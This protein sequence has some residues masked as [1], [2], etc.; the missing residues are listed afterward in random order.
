M[1][2]VRRADS[3]KERRDFLAVGR[4]LHE[5]DPIWT[6]PLYDDLARTLSPDNPLFQDGRA[7]RELY[8]AYRGERAVGRVLGHVHHAHNQRHG[9]RAGFFG[10]LECP[11]ELEV[12]RALVDAVAARH[13]ARGLER[14]RGPYELTIS[15]CIGAVVSGFD[16]PASTSQ[17]WNAPH[18]PRL[19]AELGFAPVYGAK[20]FR[21]D[22]VAGCDED[23][24]LGDKHRAW[25]ADPRVRVRA[26]DMTRFDD[27][28]HAAMDLLNQ[29]FAENYGFVPLSEPEVEFF[30]RPMK[31]LVRPELTVFL[32]LDGEPVSVGMVL[33]DFNVLVRAMAGELWPFGWAKFLLGSRAVRAGVL[34]FIATS[35]ALQN[36]GLMRIVLAELVR[37]LKAHG[38]TSL[39]VTWI[40]D[41]NAKSQAHMRAL[42]MREKH[43]LTLYERPL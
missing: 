20:V 23:A 42:G 5:G 22:D 19:L 32:E 40:G 4:E 7:E 18:L 34:Q 17:S 3:A 29:S 26:W 1:I 6:P 15:Q 28:L 25:L 27:D 35:P 12:A 37:R 14:L 24:L 30:A 2:A 16:E 36:K 43:A 21:L 41:A 38:F 11:D 39:D 33:P 8:V 13:R 9:E 31:R 10:L